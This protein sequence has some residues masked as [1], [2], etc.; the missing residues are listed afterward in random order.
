MFVV[1]LLRTANNVVG[2]AAVVDMGD[3]GG[4]FGRVGGFFIRKKV[5]LQALDQ[6]VWALIDITHIAVECV[7]R[8]RSRSAS[9]IE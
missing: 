8:Q 6:W 5:V 7:E 2:F 4:W 3:L 1:I 9:Y